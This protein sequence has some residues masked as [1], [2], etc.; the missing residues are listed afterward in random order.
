MA[1]NELW[2]WLD[3]CWCAN[4]AVQ[5]CTTCHRSLI[6]TVEI[7]DK[8]PYPKQFHFLSRASE[9]FISNALQP[10]SLN[11]IWRERTTWL[12]KKNQTCHQLKGRR[13][14][15]KYK[16]SQM[17]DSP[18]SVC[19]I[20]V[21]HGSIIPHNGRDCAASGNSDGGLEKGLTTLAP[22]VAFSLNRFRE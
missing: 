12:R 4:P 21:H 13:Q 3:L 17:R 22:L 2:V 19:S 18:S 14:Q 10:Q 20:S 8:R 9:E 1:V 6:C 16:M 15:Q 7:R 11:C 5:C